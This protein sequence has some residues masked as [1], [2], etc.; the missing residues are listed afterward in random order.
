MEQRK[1]IFGALDD[2][3]RSPIGDRLQRESVPGI[4]Y[5]RNT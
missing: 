5:K 1:K 3:M 4:I 2:L